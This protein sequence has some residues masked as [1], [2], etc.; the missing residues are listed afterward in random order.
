MKDTQ[1]IKPIEIELNGELV[2]APDN[3]QTVEA[4]M[5]LDNKT[6]AEHYLV[7]LRGKAEPREL[8]EPQEVLKLRK[9]MRF[10]TL[11]LGPA[12]VS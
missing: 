2:E 10:I 4:V 1:K 7:E 6:P 12:T 5:A 3:D 11:L 8:R 9:G